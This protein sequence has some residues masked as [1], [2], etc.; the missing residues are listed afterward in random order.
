MFVMR[1]I[2]K[3]YRLKSK[4]NKYRII[5]YC[6][7]RK[8]LSGKAEEFLRLAV[9]ET[10]NFRSRARETFPSTA[11]TY[12]SLFILLLNFSHRFSVDTL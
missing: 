8:S 12:Y 5:G 2:Q 4:P 10:G 9:G 7:G 3:L 1:H 6:R 11:P